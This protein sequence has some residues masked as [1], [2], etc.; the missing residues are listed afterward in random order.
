MQMIKVKLAC[1][2]GSVYYVN[3]IDNKFR[4]EQ[5]QLEKKLEKKDDKG[6]N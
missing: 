2:F 4:Q 6:N 1:N 5:E 3:V